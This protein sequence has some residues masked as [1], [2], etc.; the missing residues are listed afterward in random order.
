MKKLI[1]VT[2]LVGWA[3]YSLVNFSIENAANIKAEELAVIAAEKQAKIDYV[4]WTK[5]FPL[6]AK[7][8]IQKLKDKQAA[9]RAKL[10]EAVDRSY[11]SGSRYIGTY[12]VYLQN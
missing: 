6:E 7:A 9:N 1:V 10:Q 5:E 12:E 8:A 4:K 11:S 2:L 3:G